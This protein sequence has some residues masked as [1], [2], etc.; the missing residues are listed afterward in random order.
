MFCHPWQNYEVGRTAG[1]QGIPGI[2][3]KYDLDAIAVH[4]REKRRPIGQFLISM[5]GIVGGI[6]ATT[7]MLHGFGTAMVA[8]KAD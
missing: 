3:F 8:K 1:R 6:F 5:C 2:Y 4:V 7:G